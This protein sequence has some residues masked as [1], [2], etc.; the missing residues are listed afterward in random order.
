LKNTFLPE[1][2]TYDSYIQQVDSLENKT[3]T[4]LDNQDDLDLIQLRR[5]GATA[6]KEFFEK[7]ISEDIPLGEIS[8]IQNI[9]H[10]KTSREFAFTLRRKRLEEVSLDKSPK[11]EKNKDFWS[12]LEKSIIFFCKHFRKKSM[13][14]AVEDTLDL[15]NHLQ[16]QKF[17]P[18]L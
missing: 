16:K 3:R 10:S 12:N 4:W 15:T 14:T 9:I 13:R 2:G 5:S 6:Q 17:T 8:K 7:M 18:K 11:L 1:D